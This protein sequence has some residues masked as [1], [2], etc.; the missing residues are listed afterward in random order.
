VA[1]ETNCFSVGKQLKSG[2]YSLD[3]TSTFHPYD[4]NRTSNHHHGSREQ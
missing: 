4:S 2:Q 1:W 3:T